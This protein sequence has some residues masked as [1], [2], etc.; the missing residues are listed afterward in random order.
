MN[1]VIE[2]DHLLLRTFTSVDATL[3]YELNLDPEV[4]RYTFDPIKD[5]YKANDVLEKTILPQY[6][7]HNYGRWA[8]HLK[9]DFQFIG[10]CGL[11]TRPERDEIDLG[12]RFKK[13]FWGK[14]YATEAAIA[15]IKYGFET[16]YLKRIVGRAMPDNKASIK[17]LEN[18]GMTYIKDEV[19]DGHPAITYE[20]LNPFIP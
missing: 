7:L 15:C 17:V 5:I 14:G 4:T 19:V 11:K 20:I 2:T 12:Y 10:W 6:T 16:L 9:S 3:I 1:V 18:C 8:V 13:K